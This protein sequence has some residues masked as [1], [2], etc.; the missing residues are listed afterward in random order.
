MRWIIRQ[1]WAECEQAATR[2]GVNSFTAQLLYNRGLT[3]RDEVQ[4]F[5]SPHA[6]DLPD[7]SLLPHAEAAAEL[8]VRQIADRRRIVIYGDYDVDGI[9]GSA[10]LWHLLR[11]AGADVSIYTPHRIEEGYGVNSEALTT[12]REQGA[13]TVVT[14]DCGITAVEQAALARRL[15]LTLII[16]DHHALGDKLPEADALVHPCLNDQ[17]PN[18]HLCGAGVAF[19]LAW[20][21][22]RRL[23]ARPGD[24]SAGRGDRISEPLRGCLLEAMGLAAL[25]TIADVVPLIGE[26]RILALHGL[27]Q[28]PNSKLPGIAALVEVARI[29]NRRL[30]SE[31]VGFWLAPR[32]NA[33][34]R[35]GHAREAVELLTSADATRAREIAETLDRQNRL[36]QATERRIF[37]EA[38]RQIDEQRLAGDARRGIVVASAKWHAGVVGIVAS[39]VVERYGRPTVLIA[40]ENGEGQGSARS[41]A[42][43][44]LHRALA[45]CG[46][47]LLSYGGHAKAA[48]LRIAADCVEAFTRAF[49]ERANQYLT[50]KDLDASLHL[51]AELPLSQV[52]DTLVR[53]LGRLRPF[54]EGNPKP[55]F[56][57]TW[58]TLDGQ[59][60]TVGQNNDHLAF[61][62]S[63]G[64]I[65]RRAIAFRQARHLDRLL[66]HRR[67]RVAF[68]PMANTFNGQTSIE[69]RVVDMQ[70]PDFS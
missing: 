20:A 16:T 22:A 70:F 5:L 47:H 23:S 35:M 34:G 13:E 37:E 63:E 68:E 56:A 36:R 48:G 1:P 39:R 12:L 41:V 45:D 49:V 46:A 54:G 44:E 50:A 67:C 40:I 33:A 3:S 43:F 52:T 51:E 10:I 24:R 9:A 65:Q 55:L 57:S 21:L 14:V 38:C 27:N 19:K 31:H 18:R 17:Y 28:L 53:T 62:L 4:A 7:P 42:H 6:R 59:P 26:N 29:E 60:R 58:L 61:T 32:L 15:G 66:E 11:T 30:E 69:L 8:L 64:S 25:G 2:L